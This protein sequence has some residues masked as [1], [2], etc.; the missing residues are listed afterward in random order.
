METG[1]WFLRSANTGISALIDPDGEIVQ[2]SK[3]FEQ[4]VLRGT[5][6]PRRGQ[7]P[8]QRYG[9]VPLWVIS[10]IGVGVG[11]WL[12]RRKPTPTPISPIS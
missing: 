3:Q 5:A 2:R 9:N 8:Y 12:G 4:A 1:R 11:F 7:T 10:I 6:E